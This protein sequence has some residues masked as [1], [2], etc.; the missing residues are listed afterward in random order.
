MGSQVHKA[1]TFERND[2][3]ELSKGGGATRVWTV[4]AAEAAQ[5][6]TGSHLV[7]RNPSLPW[8]VR[9]KETNL[10]C[11]HPERL[12]QGSAVE[13]FFNSSKELFV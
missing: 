5:I 7:V 1:V 12:S 13:V 3:S 2:R 6:H 9:L 4:P 8:G 11:P 10:K